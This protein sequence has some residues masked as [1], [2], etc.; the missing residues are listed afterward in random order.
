MEFIGL[1][2][3]AAAV[4]GALRMLTRQPEWAELLDKT[5]DAYRLGE[6]EEAQV[7]FEQLRAQ[8]RGWRNLLHVAERLM[9]ARAYVSALE[10]V[11][12]ALEQQ[13][14][15][16]KLRR[17]K[18]LL[19]A[20]M[21]RPD[22]ARLLSSWVDAHPTDESALLELG[23]LLLKLRHQEELVAYLEPYAQ[24]HPRALWVHSLLGRGYFYAGE[25]EL[26]QQY[27]VKA[28]S[29]RALRRRQ[30]VPM[31][32]VGMET[33]YDFRLAPEG[34]WEEEQD[35]LLLEQIASGT[36][37]DQLAT[38]DDRSGTAER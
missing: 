23:Q 7:L 27:L 30:A 14:R 25:L 9:S 35:T 34:Q 19:H 18:A 16:D 3:V 4:A 10:L 1:F 24:R 13:P 33:G 21:V 15:S 28:Q 32:D 26:A 37:L 2:L 22:A 20:R 8:V 36:A 38:Y 29:I 11:E 17:L 5:V 6:G 12:R 31:Y